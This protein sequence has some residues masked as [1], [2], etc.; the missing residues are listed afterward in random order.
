MAV[1]E[2]PILQQRKKEFNLLQKLY[3]LYLQVM[4]AIDGYYEIPWSEIDTDII[5]AEL[6][7]FQN[8]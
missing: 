5:I 8:K 4:R 1:T 6:A 3:G 7:E 2:Y